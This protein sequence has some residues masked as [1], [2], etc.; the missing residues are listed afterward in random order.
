MAAAMGKI[1]VIIFF[2]NHNGHNAFLFITLP[3]LNTLAGC[4]LKAGMTY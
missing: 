1:V 4:P 2:L 3:H